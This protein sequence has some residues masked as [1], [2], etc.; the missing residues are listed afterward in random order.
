MRT[1]RA[2]IAI[3][4]ILLM[5]IY[6]V[7]SMIFHDSVANGLKCGLFFEAGILLPGLVITLLLSA[8]KDSIRINVIE[9]FVYAYCIGQVISIFAYILMMLGLNIR[10]IYL[11]LIIASLLLCL[12]CIHKGVLNDF[13]LKIEYSYT[14]VYIVSIVSLAIFLITFFMI[15]CNYTVPV[16]VGN[17]F[18][19]DYLYG[20]GNTIEL[21]M[22]YPPVN[23]RAIFQENYSYH[24]LYNLQLA[25]MKR[26]TGMDAFTM[27]T[28]YTGIQSAL[29]LAGSAYLFVSK[30]IKNPKW[31]F[32]ALLFIFFSTGNEEFTLV[33][34]IPHIFFVPNNLDISYANIFCC[35]AV[36]MRQMEKEK[37]VP[38]YYVV[39]AAS[40][41]MSL[42]C[43]APFACIGLAAVGIL[44]WYYIYHKK[45]VTSSVLYI[46]T[47]AAILGILYFTI[48]KE[49]ASV[50]L[51][52]AN[53]SGSGSNIFYY[54]VSMGQIS[55]LAENIIP[56]RLIR[57]IIL[58]IAD[59]F[60]SN[61][62]AYLL[63]I[64]AAVFNITSRK[65]DIIDIMLLCSAAAG[66]FL[67]RFISHF[68]GSQIY[69]LF[70]SYAYVIVYGIRGIEG[71]E[72]WVKTGKKRIGLIILTGGLFLIGFCNFWTKTGVY[73]YTSLEK[74]VRHILGDNDMVE[75]LE[76]H[77]WAA[78]YVTP[79]EYEAY[80]WLREHTDQKDIIITNMCIAGYT[81]YS[82]SAGVFSE[83]QVYVPLNE[84][85]DIIEKCY[86]GNID[87]LNEVQREHNVKY[88]VQVKR[89][90]PELSLQES[91]AQKAFEN[92][93][94][95]IY[96]LLGIKE[97]VPA[98]NLE[99]Q[100]AR[101]ESYGY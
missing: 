25:V 32:I 21:S 24:Y 3:I 42:G 62:P 101:W 17:S 97:S 100:T 53:S 29:F 28:Y 46:I 77:S 72:E 87:T 82:Y 2:K 59:C 55:R 57:E 45:A 12:T 1:T 27:T 23:F 84:D 6:I 39:A 81:R 43:K 66:I 40:F 69:F 31:I 34:Y 63:L 13:I 44:G 35:L 70:A 76:H 60:I 80:V 15:S 20:V 18:Y 91:Y 56:Y 14:S 36:M 96:E 86:E 54:W 71:K 49:N 92:D 58:T 16:D 64:I 5:G 94:V 4:S 73:T 79:K 51:K 99:K 85:L 98:I 26:I 8:K 7:I 9:L 67:V 30:I 74:G 89:I 38:I 61:Y 88:L 78:N 37:A 19:Q 33:T 90:T 68:G 41:A 50:N 48:L 11:S 93:E 75:Y 52:I 83:R 47:F 65:I 10:Y 95:I 22:E